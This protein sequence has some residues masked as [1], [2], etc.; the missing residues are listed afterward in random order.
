MKKSVIIIL[1]LHFVSI[2]V[3]QNCYRETRKEAISAF[4]Q[5]N[6]LVLLDKRILSVPNKSLVLQDHVPIN[7]KVMIWLIG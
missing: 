7:Q 6:L 1:M 4:G 3:A 5:K 2:I